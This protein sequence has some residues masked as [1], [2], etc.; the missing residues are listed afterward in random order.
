MVGLTTERDVDE[1]QRVQ[2]LGSVRLQKRGTRET[3]LI[4]TPSADPN[5]P[6]NWYHHHSTRHKSLRLTFDQVKQVPVL[7]CRNCMRSSLLLQLPCGGT[8]SCNC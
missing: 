8:N 3:I 5:D 1:I 7:H 6:L 2:T 4:P